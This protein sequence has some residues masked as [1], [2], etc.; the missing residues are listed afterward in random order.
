MSLAD[1]ASPA[2]TSI[3]LFAGTTALVAK[4]ARRSVNLRAYEKSRAASARV[5]LQHARSG[6][7][8]SA[9]VTVEV[10]LQGCGGG[11]AGTCTVPSGVA[12]S[13]RVPRSR[14]I[15]ISLG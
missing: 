11:S 10:F 6:H 14:I 9:G 8:Y 15:D 1:K 12:C 3:P 2:D 5:D 13:F 7:Q 4:G